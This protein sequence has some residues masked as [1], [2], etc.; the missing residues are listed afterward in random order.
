MVGTTPS[1]IG[2]VCVAG[3]VGKSA[4][5]YTDAVVLSVVG[6]VYTSV[7]VAT[8]ASRVASNATVLPVVVL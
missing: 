8:G 5:A 4:L 6:A 1:N 2:N 7:S 3:Y